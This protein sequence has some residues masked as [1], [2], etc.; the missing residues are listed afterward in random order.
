MGNVVVKIVVFFVAFFRFS[1]IFLF[2]LFSSCF[3]LFPR[4]DCD[5]CMCVCVSP[6]EIEE[7]VRCPCVY[8]CTDKQ[9]FTFHIISTHT[10]TRE[11]ARH[12]TSWLPKNS[13][14]HAQLR[15]KIRTIAFHGRSSS[16]THQ[17]RSTVVSTKYSINSSSDRWLVCPTRAPSACCISIIHS[18]HNIVVHTYFKRLHT[19]IG[20]ASRKTASI[21]ALAANSSSSSGSQQQI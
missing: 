8:L 19:S 15:R 13:T 21:S 16:S 20:R 11:R 4:T 17:W 1:Q 3:C 18:A 2:L 14:E 9:Q 5:L 12:V 7:C 10:Y 6:V